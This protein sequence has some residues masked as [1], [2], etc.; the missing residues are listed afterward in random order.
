[1]T[2]LRSLYD[3]FMTKVLDRLRDPI[4]LAL[5][6]FIGWQFYVSGKAHLEHIDGFIQFFTTLHIPAPA[7]NAYFVA[8]LEMIGGILMF[9][10]LASRLIA[11][12]LAIDMIVAYL[13]ADHDAVVNIFKDPDTFIAATPFPFLLV[14]LVVLA[15]GPGR[16]SIDYVLRKIVDKKSASPATIALSSSATS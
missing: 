7:L 8:G 6:L 2:K 16:I 5:R 13:T 11:I 3:A 4:L 10:G 14:S 1:M 9:V 12:P 15:V